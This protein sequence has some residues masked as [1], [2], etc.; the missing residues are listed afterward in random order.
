MNDSS[1]GGESGAVEE[2]FNFEVYAYLEMSCCSSGRSWRRETETPW[3]ES[4]ISSTQVPMLTWLGPLESSKSSSAKLTLFPIDPSPNR[5]NSD[6]RIP[7]LRW[8][9]SQRRVSRSFVTSS[10]CRRR[11]R[12]SSACLI[13]TTWWSWTRVEMDADSSEY[14]LG[15]ELRPI[16][17]GF[18]APPPPY[19]LY[20]WGWC[21]KL[22]LF[23]LG[24]GTSRR[25][26]GCCR[27]RSIFGVFG[28]RN[29][30]SMLVL[31]GPFWTWIWL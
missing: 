17:I 1:L 6:A 19:W 2:D 18:P 9:T 27:S 10:N 15:L 3:T 16:I 7:I 29:W 4:R 24:L 8:W 14:D 22:T 5:P 28:A 11:R 30:L 26:S 23:P 31:S 20:W 12:I 21:W 13:T 25:K